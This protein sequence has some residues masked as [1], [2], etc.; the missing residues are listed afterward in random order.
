MLSVGAILLGIVIL[1]GVW[2][3]GKRYGE[4]RVRAEASEDEAAQETRRV[5]ALE[6]ADA[7]ADADREVKDN[8]EATE[9][10]ATTDATDGLEFLRNSFKTTH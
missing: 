3:N 7:Q 2:Y 9:A 6:K 4:T 1:F 8:R 5:E 10:T